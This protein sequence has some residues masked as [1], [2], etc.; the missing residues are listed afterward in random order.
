MTADTTLTLRRILKAPRDLVWQCW[1]TPELLLPWFCP[2]PHKTTEAIIDLRPGGRFFTRMH[3]DGADYP[4]DGSYLHVDPGH[5][6]VFTDMM[7]AD[8]QPASDP[9]L[10][11]TAELIFRDHPEGTD[12]TAIARHRT[13]ESAEQHEQMGFSRG[14]GTV[15]EQ[16]EAY[17]RAGMH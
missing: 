10:G 13:P 2:R 8:W 1:T 4:N 9:G 7:L 5:A 16:L 12:Y 6:L 14:W 11:F 3:V 17:I 15:A